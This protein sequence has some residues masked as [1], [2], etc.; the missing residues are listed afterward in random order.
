[1]QTDLHGEEGLGSCDAHLKEERWAEGIIRG[2]SFVA[3]RAL[4]LGNGAGV[5]FGVT[6]GWQWELGVMELHGFTHTF[7]RLMRPLPFM[8]KAY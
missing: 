6:H 7:C 3:G 4:G 2:C 8:G 1:M 5:S